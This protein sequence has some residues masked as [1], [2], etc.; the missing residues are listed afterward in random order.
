MIPSHSTNHPAT[1]RRRRRRSHAVWNCRTPSTPLIP[2]KLLPDDESRSKHRRW[3]HVSARKLAAGLWQLPLAAPRESGDGG[4]GNTIA[5]L[6]CRSSDFFAFEPGFAHVNTV[7]P[8]HHFGL[9]CGAQKLEM[10]WNP[11][12][13]WSFKDGT[14]KKVES[15]LVYPK[16]IIKQATKW[17]PNYSR[18]AGKNH[19]VHRQMKL[20][21]EETSTEYVSSAMQTELVQA[22]LRIHELEADL[23]PF[24][25]KID[26]LLQKLGEERTPRQS[27]IN[28]KKVVAVIDKLKD[29]IR[30][31]RQNYRRMKILNS[32]LINELSIAQSSSKKFRQDYEE[33]KRARELITE[34]C[35]DLVYQ[36]AE[37]KDEIE[38][39]KMET[40][41]IQEEIEEERKMLQMAEV[42]REARVQM[43]L[44]DAKLTL[45]DK[46]RQINRLIKD[47]ETSLRR[48]G[49]TN[50]DVMEFIKEEA[51]K[52]NFENIKEFSY[53]P[54]K[55]G[56]IYSLFEELNKLEEAN[57]KETEACI[58]NKADTPS[59]VVN[60]YHDD[61]HSQNNA[62]YMDE[63]YELEENGKGRETTRYPEDQGS[64]R[65]PEG[66]SCLRERFTLD[67]RSG[68]SSASGECNDTPNQNSPNA[69]I[70]DFCSSTLQKASSTP[71]YP[72]SGL[73][74]GESHQPTLITCTRRLNGY[75]T[76]RASAKR[77]IRISKLGNQDFPG[78]GGSS[79][80]VN[81]HVV[82]GMKGCIEW[83]RCF[84]KLNSLKPDVLESRM[85]RQTAQL[86]VV[87]E[88]KPRRGAP[89]L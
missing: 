7:F 33:E 18:I 39:L 19:L 16:Y 66:N 35:N 59:S 83:A 72:R 38:T 6:K 32:E 42:W 36:I 27:I 87:L 40:I 15:S 44:I 49:S 53:V 78:R 3:V 55:S 65:S 88:Q 84:Q 4:G 89:I 51:Q 71:K 50:L 46:H 85:E 73:R 9:E 47:V 26:H 20:L 79:C 34:V 10:F 25:E 58:W 62:N 75:T 54:P 60:D 48:S 37:S 1:P 22:Q 63:V 41:G 70:T 28:S 12:T 56:D 77:K 64:C 30:K 68:W 13:I 82:Q 24:K 31:E 8:S 11:R 69:Q 61:Q 14:S 74:I 80:S 21:G 17:D 43:K 29:K 86:R 57:E 81:P 5:T 67:K 45:E 52:V 23:R 2:W 76:E